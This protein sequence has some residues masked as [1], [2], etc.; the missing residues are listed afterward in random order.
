MHAQ[1]ARGEYIIG[2]FDTEM[3]VQGIVELS[4]IGLGSSGI[5]ALT[6]VTPRINNK[7]TVI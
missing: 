2:G 7:S 1:W 3:D 4:I 5:S 6:L